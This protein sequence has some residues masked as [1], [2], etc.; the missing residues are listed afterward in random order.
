MA[1]KHITREYSTSICFLWIQWSSVVTVAFLRLSQLFSCK[2]SNDIFTNAKYIY[3]NVTVTACLIFNT[4]SAKMVSNVT[5]TRMGSA[6][7]K[8]GPRMFWCSARTGPV[9]KGRNNSASWT[10]TMSY[11][12]YAKDNLDKASDVSWQQKV[13]YQLI[14]LDSPICSRDIF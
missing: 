2:N 6:L 12:V 13:K 4:F 3:D 9:R 11:L 10:W 5:P 8:G 1:V 7:W 14:W